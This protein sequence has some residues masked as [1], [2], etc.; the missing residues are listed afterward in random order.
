MNIPSERRDDPTDGGGLFGS[1]DRKDSMPHRTHPH[2]MSDR[3]EAGGCESVPEVSEPW[4]DT[5]F[6]SACQESFGGPLEVDPFDTSVDSQGVPKP[7]EVPWPRFHPIPTRPVF[8]GG[9]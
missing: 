9:L 8:G 1:W 4:T 7:P 6:D 3:W 5:S 2:E